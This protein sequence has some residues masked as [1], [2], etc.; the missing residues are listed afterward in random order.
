[1]LFLD[2]I[3]KCKL[4]KNLMYVY[5]MNI[6]IDTFIILKLNHT[7]LKQHEGDKMMT[8]FPVYG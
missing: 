2:P 4:E 7:G 6:Y 8:Q 5:I 3:E 1:M